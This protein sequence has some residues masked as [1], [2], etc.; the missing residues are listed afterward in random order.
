M[1]MQLTKKNK[2]IVAMV[3]ISVSEHANRFKQLLTFIGGLNNS[4]MEPG[5]TKHGCYVQ[6]LCFFLRSQPQNIGHNSKSR[7]Y[8][9][10]GICRHFLEYWEPDDTVAV[11]PN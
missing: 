3:I 11:A 8:R 4:C 7:R 1:Q 2:N 10:P 6:G 5:N 9:A